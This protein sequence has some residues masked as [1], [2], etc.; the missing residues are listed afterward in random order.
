[1]SGRFAKAGICLIL[2]LPVVYFVHNCSREK[3]DIR[4]DQVTQTKKWTYDIVSI[5]LGE[6]MYYVLIDGELDGDAALE[7]ETQ[8]TTSNLN[9]PDTTYADLGTMRLPKGKFSIYYNR[10][11]SGPEKFVYLPLKATKGWIRVQISPGLWSNK[12]SVRA[13]PDFQ[14]SRTYPI[15]IRE[16]NTTSKFV[17]SR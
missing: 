11:D 16:N 5:P 7:I 17:F 6:R 1:M 13:D 12:D 9:K 2:A 14:S 3:Q 15:M 10:D 8:R 4:I